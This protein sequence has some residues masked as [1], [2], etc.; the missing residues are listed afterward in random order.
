MLGKQWVLNRHMP[1]VDMSIRLAVQR[2][3]SGINLLTVESKLC[4]IFA[5]GSW[6]C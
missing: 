5:V 1:S 4:N 3:S 6:E 2:V